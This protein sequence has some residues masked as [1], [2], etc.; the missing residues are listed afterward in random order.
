MIDGIPNRPLYFYQ[1]DIK[2]V[3]IFGRLEK[4]QHANID[5][6]HD[7]VT[8]AKMGIEAAQ[9]G[10]GSSWVWWWHVLVMSFCSTHTRI[11]GRWATYAPS[12]DTLGGMDSAGCPASCLPVAWKK[13]TQ[14]LNDLNWTTN[15]I[16][17]LQYILE[18]PPMDHWPIQQP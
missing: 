7:I 15:R 3:G 13:G 10:S 2:L 9:G 5:S 12:S 1:K 4:I 17:R 8:D 18:V 6:F 16:N 11:P 14:K